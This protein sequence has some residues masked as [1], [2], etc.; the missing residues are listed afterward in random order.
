MTKDK[1]PCTGVEQVDDQPDANDEP[2]G[3]ACCG[4]VLDERA[5]AELLNKIAECTDAKDE[6]KQ[7]ELPEA[8]RRFQL[9]D[10]RWI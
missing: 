9:R 5:D 1:F 6:E 4:E 8:L 2:K 10:W 7:L 3:P